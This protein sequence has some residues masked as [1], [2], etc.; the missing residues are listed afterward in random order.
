M[1]F[2]YANT[3][4]GPNAGGIGW[5]DFGPS[6]TITPGQT[7]T[8]SGSLRNNINVTFDMTLVNVP[9]GVPRNYQAVPAPVP[10]AFFG[11]AGYTGLTGN[12]ILLGDTGTANNLSNMVFSNISVT[13]AQGN[14]MPNF[15]MVFA[16]GENTSSNSPVTQEGLSFTTNGGDWSVLTT[17]GANNPP[18]FIGGGQ[19]VGLIGISPPPNTAYVLTT[20]GPTQT[21]VGLSA[22][23]PTDRNGIAVGFA[24]TQVELYKV[25][26]GRRFPADQFALSIAGNPAVTATTTGAA[27]GLQ[28]VYA[29]ASAI[30]GTAYTLNEVMAPGSVS[31]LTDYTQT[32]TAV[33]LTPGGTTP[34]VGPLPESVTP[35]LGDIIQYT[36]TNDPSPVVAKTASPAFAESGD[37]LTYTVTVFNPSSTTPLN[38]VVVTDPTPSGTTYADSLTVS[39]P[40]TGTDPATGITL[41]SIPVLTTATLTWQVQVNPGIPTP[42]PISNVATIALPGGETVTTNAALTQVN[43]ADLTAPGNFVKTAIPTGAGPGDTVTYSFSITNTGNV[44]ADNVVITEP[45]PAGTTF[46]PGSVTGATGTPPTLTLTSPIPAGGTAVVTFQ[47]KIN[48]G[49]PAVNPIPN[50]A[51]IAYNYTVDPADPDGGSGS[52]TS[53]T[54]TVAVSAAIVT[55]TKTADKVIAY[56][57]DTITYNIAITNSGNVPADNVVINDPLAAGLTYVAGSLTGSVPVTGAPPVITVSN[58]IA[59]G[60]TVNVSFKVLVTA[61]PNP[62]PTSNVATVNFTY[63]VDPEDPDGVTGTSTSNGAG[64]TVFLN[65]YS[66]QVSDLIESVALQEAALAAIMQAE[67]AK[68]QRIAATPGVTPRELLCLNKS[69]S[70]MTDSIALLEAIL[71]QKLGTVEC[72]ITG[73]C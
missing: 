68:I 40:Y 66:Q 56:V 37:L 16:D 32:V 59:P 15:T 48:N 41:T 53:N 44:A 22:P 51:T 65:N 33:N 1:P 11:L 17:V 60:Q 71:K 62:N 50:T 58:P 5:F 72:Q 47:V 43:A 55:T 8:L 52:G 49:I 70:D 39:V 7:V 57:G 29:T 14:P 20:Q 21:V 67:G 4:S 9:G 69:V 64:T 2:V 12:P 31:A 10:G 26:N 36:I 42:N 30:P 63:T 54:A 13:D 73:G 35:V 3:G 18:Q 46:V 61:Q 6:F 19:F 27:N 45:V 25:L 23:L 24:A 38:G 28:S 34:I